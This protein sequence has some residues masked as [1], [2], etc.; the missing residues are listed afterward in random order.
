MQCESCGEEI[1]SDSL[2]C[3][4]CGSRV[5][6][7]GGG[8]SP[9]PSPVPAPAHEPISEIPV[10]PSQFQQP[11]NPQGMMG[12]EQV[13]PNQIDPNVGA[14]NFLSSLAADMTAV[15]YTHL[16]AHET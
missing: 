1:P 15:S 10:D 5:N 9:A 11:I 16:R 3:P 4:E 14:Q 6:A 2:F 12:H 13:Q 7:S 8:M